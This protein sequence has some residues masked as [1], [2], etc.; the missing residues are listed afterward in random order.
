MSNAGIRFS[1]S[2]GLG[3]YILFLVIRWNIS[4]FSYLVKTLNK[5]SRMSKKWG[6]GIS[7]RDGGGSAC[8]HDG[9]VV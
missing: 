9:F 5:R 1:Q 2:R 6:R 3:C 8:P 7:A 4:G